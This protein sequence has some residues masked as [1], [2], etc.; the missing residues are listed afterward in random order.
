MVLEMVVVAT[1]GDVFDFFFFFDDCWRWGM[2]IDD[3]GNIFL[4]VSKKVDGGRGGLVAGCGG[5]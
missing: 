4:V 5:G 2:A 3:V 1:G